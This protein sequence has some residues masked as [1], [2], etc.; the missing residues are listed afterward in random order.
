MSIPSV[1]LVSSTDLIDVDN[2]TVFLKKALNKR[3][4]DASIE[5]WDNPKVD[6]SE[7]ELV[8]SRTTST[9]LWSGNTK[10]FLEWTKK[11]EKQSTLWNS[12]KLIEWRAR[13]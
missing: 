8:I 4:I 12:R 1:I 2:E 10:K 5:S 11:V 3:G 6:W 7:A 13:K 9:Y